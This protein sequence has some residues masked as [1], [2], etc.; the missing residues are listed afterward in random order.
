MIL[1]FTFH[2][3]S[4]LREAA[5]ICEHYRPSLS[6]MKWKNNDCKFKLSVKKKSFL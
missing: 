3:K 4:N 6:H 5:V 2:P 1:W